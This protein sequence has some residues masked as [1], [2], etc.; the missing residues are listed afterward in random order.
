MFFIY[1]R[2]SSCD[3]VYNDLKP[4]GARVMEVYENKEE[5]RS[6]IRLMGGA[7]IQD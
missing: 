5:F 2:F 3:T 6:W 1:G 7:I 4:N